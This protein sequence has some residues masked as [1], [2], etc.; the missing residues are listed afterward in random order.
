[1]LRAAAAFVIAGRAKDFKKGIELANRSI[2]S[3]KAFNAL[4]RLVE[5]TNAE[6]TYIRKAY[7][8]HAE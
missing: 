5:F 8:A 3:G 4:E 2:D 7:E 6:S 1:M